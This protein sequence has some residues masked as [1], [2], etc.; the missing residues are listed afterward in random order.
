[1]QHEGG[2]PDWIQGEEKPICK[3]CEQ[4]MTFMGQIDSIGAAETPLGRSLGEANAFVFADYGMICMF[5]RRGCN[6][7]RAVLQC[8]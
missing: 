5:W 6:D 7:T 8:Y 3:H 1:M 4:P 2:K